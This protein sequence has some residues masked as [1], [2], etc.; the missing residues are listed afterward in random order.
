[1]K[2]LKSAKSGQ[3]SRKRKLSEDSNSDS[4][5]KSINSKYKGIPKFDH[6]KIFKFNLNT[7]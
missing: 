5:S 2:S 6:S 3:L 7:V 4:D 1:M